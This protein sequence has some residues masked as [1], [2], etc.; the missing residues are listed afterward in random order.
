LVSEGFRQG[1]FG[2]LVLLTTQ[3]T[4]FQTNLAYLDSLRDLRTAGAAI[5]GNL[6]TDSLQ[7]AEMSS[8]DGVDRNK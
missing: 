4:Y 1:E 2:Y 8:K 6:L 5:E 7:T 3:R